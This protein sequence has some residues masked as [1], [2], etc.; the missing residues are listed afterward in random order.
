MTL[1]EMITDFFSKIQSG[2][3][4]P[5]IGGLYYLLPG[6]L[7]LALVA[8]VAMLIFAQ[9][10]STKIGA[11]VTI[12]V[13]AAIMPQIPDVINAFMSWFGG[14]G[15]VDLGSATDAAKEG[16]DSGMAD[17]LGSLKK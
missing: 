10:M 2:I 17:T 4:D 14:S 3:L 11:V 9:R 1:P 12:M 8:A 7:V 16:I 5:L 15:N 6:L 13:I